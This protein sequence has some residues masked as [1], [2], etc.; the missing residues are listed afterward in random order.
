MST[1]SRRSTNGRHVDPLAPL[2]FVRRSNHLLRA[3]P[4]RVF[5]HLFV[6]GQ[7]EYGASELRAARVMQRVTALSES[8]V[9]LAL[10]D[11]HER[12]GDR[13][14]DLH[15]WLDLH[16]HRVAGRL[17]PSLSM[18]EDRWRLLGSV[19]T[20]EFSVEGASLTN[21]SMVLH[22]SQD[23]LPPGSARFVLSVRCIGEGHRSSIGFRTGT[24]SADGD[25]TIDDP[26]PNLNP[27]LRIDT[28]MKRSV[29]ANLLEQYHG[30]GE[31]SMSVLA[32][33][34]ATFDCN[35]LETQLIRLEHDRETFRN[36]E[37]T[38]YY[39]RSIAERHYRVDFAPDVHLSERILWPHAAVERHGM[40]DLRLVRF[41]NGFGPASY[42]GTYTGY[43]GRA[44]AQQMLRT[45]DFLS[46]EM[47]PA[48]GEGASGKGLALFPRL[49]G[50]S[51]AALSRADHE[52]NSIGFSDELEVWK[53]VAPVQMP[54]GGTELIQLGNCGSP[55][56][57]EAGWLVL[58][59][60]VGPMRTYTI[61]ATLLDIDDPT[62][63]LGVLDRPLVSPRDDQ[64]DGY[65]PNVV[66]SCGSLLHGSNLVIPLGIADQSIGFAV[67]PIEPL[68]ERLVANGRPS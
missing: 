38:S 67:S 66:Y 61:G 4:T 9:R 16:A 52:S 30:L 13:H 41:E 64:R 51:F 48:A 45:P 11:V 14:P 7:E 25:L 6:A 28:I 3:D 31:H 29:F 15:Y 1:T 49:I 26:R 35:T 39:F 55:I 21:P 50:G 46:F 63:V 33:L 58:T 68:I 20:H 34:E 32:G 10:A 23:G 54:R 42:I 53:E 65:V 12:F 17:S 24:V 19:F 62:R 5:M 22:P 59:H 56:E 27:G 2:E 44:I 57:T 37:M 43:D 36:T 18:S 60:A 8:E 40:E 47:H